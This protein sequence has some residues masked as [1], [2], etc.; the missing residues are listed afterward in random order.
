MAGNRAGG[1]DPL[2][3]EILLAL[4]DHVKVRIHNL[5]EQR[6]HC[7]DLGG[8]STCVRSHVTQ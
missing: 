1:N 7:E 5:F 3:A 6:L 2:V 8:L 4:P